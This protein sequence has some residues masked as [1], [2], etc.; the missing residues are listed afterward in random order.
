M[1]PDMMIFVAVFELNACEMFEVKKMGALIILY[2]VHHSLQMGSLRS[3]FLLPLKVPRDPSML[4]TDVFEPE[5]L[6]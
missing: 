4:R 6:A 2:I 1:V 3:S 5:I